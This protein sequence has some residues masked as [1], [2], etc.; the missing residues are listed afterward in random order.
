MRGA[1]LSL[2]GAVVAI[3]GGGRGI[4][5]ATAAA[6]ARRGARVAIGDLDAEVAHGTAEAL[7]DRVTAFSLDVT[8]PDSFAEFVGAVE[9]AA[10]P[11]DVLVNNAGIMPVGSFL[12]ES[13][14]TTRAVFEINVAGTITGMRLVL[15]AMVE[16]GRG[17]VVNVAS[18]AGRFEI[19]GLATY[20]ASKHAVVGLT[21]TVA[22]E[23]EGTGVTLT[24]VLPSAVHTEL[25]AGIAFPF[26]A[27]AK[28]APE[29]VAGAIVASCA[30]HRL[31]VTV[32]R[33]LAPYPALA[34][35][36]P[37]LLDR[38]IRRRLGDD[39]ALNRVDAIAR[40]AYEERIARQISAEA[41][42]A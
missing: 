39:R 9:R 2:D 8:S 29:D 28:V 11:I 1:D 27:V 6:F 5:R 36:I 23:L 13:P 31:E 37:R 4:G 3:T 14:R 18:G 38:W 7:G 12:E 42:D 25:S 22:R 40:G 19:P 33:W 34:A 35:L 30:S 26:E 20:C 17:H 10:G 21:G 41:S 32:P 16:R 24:A 15:P